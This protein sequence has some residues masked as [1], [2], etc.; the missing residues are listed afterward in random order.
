M[1][2]DELESHKNDDS[3]DIDDELEDTELDEDTETPADTEDSDDQK[4]KE[5]AEEAKERQKKAWIAKIKGGTK[6]LD[7]MPENLGWLKKEIE[8]E[9]KPKKPAKK[10]DVEEAVRKTLQKEREAEDF[11]ALTEYLEEA[12]LS[13]ELMAKIEEDYNELRQ[14]GL[15]KFR[16]LKNAMRLNG[17]KDTQEVVMERRR[18]GRRLPPAGS[19]VR[20]T[21]SKDG[22]SEIERKLSGGLPP[23]YKM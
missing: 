20:K 17:I 7:D 8:E 16:S 6:T 19:R 18:Q 3:Q 1:Q 13:S 9:L 23:G 5:P 14:D 11:T 10:D 12:D 21:V 2:K 15:S 22:L 4:D